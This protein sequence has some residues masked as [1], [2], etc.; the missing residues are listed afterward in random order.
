ML[1]SIHPLGERARNR[2][3]GIT[4]SAYVVGSVI[5]AGSLGFVL[6][7]VGAAL[8][9]TPVVV[10]VIVALACTAGLAFDLGIRGLRLPTVHRQVDK[11]WLDEY[12]G[13]VYGL[14]FGLQLGLGV[15]TVV[16]TAA[17]YLLL[18]LAL[19]SGSVLGGVLV[20][21]TF[22]LVRAMV[23]FRVA[24]VRSPHQLRQ[25]LQAMQAWEPRAHRAG[26]GVQAVALLAVAATALGH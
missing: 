23:I 10:A 6:G 18:V 25:A 8:P 3:W 20:G 13:W 5:G 9:T 15:I 12:R 19:L 24:G 21:V 2:R 14:G 11:D 22:G 7:L 4:V 17:V 1:A 16:N 26:V